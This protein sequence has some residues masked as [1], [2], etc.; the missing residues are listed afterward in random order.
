MVFLNHYVKA[1]H[2]SDRYICIWIFFLYIEYS[3]ELSST[4][5]PNKRLEIHKITNMVGF[6][7]N[8]VYVQMVEVT[9]GEVSSSLHLISLRNFVKRNSA[10][11][12]IP[13]GYS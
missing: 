6:V 10:V 8:E 9:W 2:F 12:G 1:E 7:E 3:E 5:Q 13:S 4:G 11:F